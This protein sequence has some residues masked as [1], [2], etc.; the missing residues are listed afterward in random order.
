MALLCFGLTRMINSLII[1]LPFKT[2]HGGVI[3]FTCPTLEGR[4]LG[5]AIPT[6]LVAFGNNV[7]YVLILL[8]REYNVV[9]VLILSLREYNFVYVLILL[10]REYN[11]VYV[12]ILLLR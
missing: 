2:P 9:Y 1:S 5:G 11:V 12:L 8:L 10:L 6:N 7:V 4:G 3:L